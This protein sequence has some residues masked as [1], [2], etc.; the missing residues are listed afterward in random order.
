[1]AGPDAE[2]VVSCNVPARSARSH[3]LN[4]TGR[5]ADTNGKIVRNNDEKIM[6]LTKRANRLSL[7]KPD[8][9]CLSH[10]PWELV[11]QRPQHLM[12][13]L[14]KEYRV[15]YVEEPLIVGRDRAPWVE[16]CC[17]SDALVRLTMH[18][19]EQTDM[20]LTFAEASRVLTR[21]INSR[22]ISNP[23]LWYYTPRALAFTKNIN[24]AF[25]VYD[26]MDE[27]SA[28]AG[29]PP[30]LI[31]WEIDLFRRADLV[32]AGGQSL[33]EAKREKH[34]RVFAFPSS[35]DTS[36][37]RRAR[38]TMAEP[39]D[40]SSIPHP[41]IGHYA[42][43]DE[44]LDTELL[45]A[46]ADARPE[47]HFVLIGPVVKIHPSSL[48]CRMN[49]HYLGRKDYSVLPAYLAGWDATFM[50]FALNGATRFISPTKTPEYLAAGRRVV[51][52]PV[53]DVVRDWGATGLVE[54]AASPCE[55]VGALERVLSQREDPEWLSR[56]DQVL[57]LS[58]WDATYAR[59]REL[60]P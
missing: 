47:W 1:L 45:A 37:F 26:C 31:Q 54:I 49:I 50:P 25:V 56:V 18:I 21:W 59:M 4:A 27:L 14:A 20:N 9:L 5:N 52:T 51:S 17:Q 39:V 38:D 42:V 55:F 29:A 57:D 16:E 6:D 11:F 34:H 40:Q 35:V 24:A 8:L 33:Y 19:P 36:H 60:L 23:V 48:P 3:Q 30:D 2:P 53:P 13:R 32:F 7:R 41:R 22:G 12:T 28:F 15:F 44:R 10:L 43:L 58:S 46:L